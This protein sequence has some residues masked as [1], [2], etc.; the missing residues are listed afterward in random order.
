MASPYK[1]YWLKA[2]EKEANSLESHE[3]WEIVPQDAS[4]AYKPLKTRWVYKIKES[5]NFFEFKARFVA[6]G[7]EQLYGLNYVDTFA[8]VVKQMAW[9]LIFALAVLYGWV[10]WKVDMISAFT[11]SN[12]DVNTLYIVPPEGINAQKYAGKL[13]LLNKA[14]YGLKQSARLW[15]ITLKE[16]LVKKLGFQALTTESCILINKAQQ[17]I[18]SIYVD[19]LA[20]I[21]PNVDNIKSFILELKKLFKLKD[22]GLIK[23]YLGI[24]IE[25]NLDKGYMK[26]YQES[27]I[28]KVLARF[29]MTDCKPKDTPMDSKVKL[30]P[31]PN[32]A[33]KEEINLFQQII[34]C[35]LFLTLATR[36]DICY[37]VIKLARFASNPSAYHMI[38]LKNVLRYLKGSK[39]LGLIYEKSPSRYISGYCDADYAGDIGT[40]KSTSG[41]SFYLASCLISWK[42]KLQ[43]IIV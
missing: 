3:T 27:Y 16:V 21:G 10:I 32:Q 43:S 11:Q 39:K 22:L 29:N 33:N 8:S 20:I 13:L 26:L 4:K 37:A 28:E 18:V 2:M 40:A 24:N 14:L 6:K 42:S 12:I 25:Y 17:L 5:P 30:E 35:L 41:L 31:N 19:D 15:F 1:D 23:D 38:A 9:R 34:G 36:P 7:F